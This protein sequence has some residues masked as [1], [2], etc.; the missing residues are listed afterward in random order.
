MDVLIHHTY[1]ADRKEPFAEMLRRILAA[2]GEAAL[3][4]AITASFA[5]SPDESS[6]SA[7]DRALKKY[8]DL[9]R[10]E[11]AEP[12]IAG[13]PAI[14]HLTGEPGGNPFPLDAL[15]TLAEGVPRSLPFNSIHI[16]LGHPEFEGNVGS[17][18]GSPG[19]IVVGD[20][21]WVNG[22]KR[23]LS[24]LY[25]VA[26]DPDSPELPAP[27]PGV[28]TVI[29]Q[30]GAPRKSSTSL[31]PAAARSEV[32]DNAVAVGELVAR[33]R[34]SMSDV[35]ARATLPHD[36]VP[37]EEA[38][39][40]LR[41]SG[42]LKPALVAAFGSRGFDCRGESGRFVLRRRTDLGNFVILDVDV[43]TWSR[44]VTAQYMIRAAGA[45]GRLRV[46][47]AVS[48]ANGLQYPIGD[49][50]NWERIVAN[51]AAVV[52]ELDQTFLQEVEEITGSSP[53]WFDPRV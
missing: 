10:F 44:M 37:L 43:G 14:R 19:G 48:A 5:D 18:G 35:L 45:D 34:D 38:L 8:P 46:P 53:E 15:L 25:L 3:V 30:L 24:A 50:A 41:E 31:I 52:D 39:V 9:G 29:E 22:R 32:S 49:E 11:S 20:N 17:G 23:S 7:V 12:L 2:F 27:P 16:Q 21:W 51:L 40:A 28:A 33:Y 6:I 1:R 36:L 26:G 13:L 42:P 4:P 47:V